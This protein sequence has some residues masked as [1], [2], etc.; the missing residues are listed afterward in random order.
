MTIRSLQADDLSRI[1]EI[2]IERFP[3]QRSTRLGPIFLRRMYEWFLL[4]MPEL[5]FVAE[6]DGKVEGFILGSRGGYGRRVFSFAL[7]EIVFCLLHQPRLLADARTYRLWHSYLRGLLPRKKGSQSNQAGRAPQSRVVSFASVAVSA[8]YPGLGIYLI[9]RLEAQARRIGAEQ[10]STSIENHNERL[11]SLYQRMGWRVKHQSQAST[12]LVK[13]L[14]ETVAEAP[15][16][17]PAVR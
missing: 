1:L 11:I 15:V 6:V 12:S 2:H 10:L 4:N 14:K 13:Q 5:A 3:H 8:R 9:Q 17:A 16:S 7:K